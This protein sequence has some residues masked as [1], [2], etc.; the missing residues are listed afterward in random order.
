MARQARERSRHGAWLCTH[1]PTLSVCDTQKLGASMSDIISLDGRRITS[2]GIISGASFQARR[3]RGGA[4]GVACARGLLT[5]PSPTWSCLLA[6]PAAGQGRLLLWQRHG[7]GGWWCCSSGR[8]GAGGR[9][10]AA[11]V[12][13]PSPLPQPPP[14]PMMMVPLQAPAAAEAEAQHALMAEWVELLRARAQADAHVAAAQATC[15]QT[16]AWQRGCRLASTTPPPG[17]P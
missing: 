17:A 2:R 12:R 5:A 9:C 13:P 14:T 7:H 8:L 16:A 15:A 6:G 4:C 3:E 1:A 10:R 11:P